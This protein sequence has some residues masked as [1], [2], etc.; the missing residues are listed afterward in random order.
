MEREIREELEERIGRVG[1]RGETG[2]DDKV[3]DALD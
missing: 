3:E 1:V 2:V